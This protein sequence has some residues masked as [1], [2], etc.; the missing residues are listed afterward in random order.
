[1]TPKPCGAGSYAFVILPALR[2][3]G[4][5]RIEERS[6]AT[7]TKAQETIMKALARQPHAGLSPL[8]RRCW[9]RQR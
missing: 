7:D 8:I 6:T 4:D 3:P 1:V 2:T 9:H 5:A